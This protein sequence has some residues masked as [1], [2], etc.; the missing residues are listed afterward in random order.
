MTGKLEFVKAQVETV[1]TRAWSVGDTGP[2]IAADPLR[3]LQSRSAHA[4]TS[5]EGEDPTGLQFIRPTD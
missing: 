2:H 3:L 1:I 4:P 5:Q